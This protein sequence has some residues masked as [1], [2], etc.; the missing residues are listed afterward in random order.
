MGSTASLGAL[1]II[2]GADTD[3]LDKGLKGAQAS[4]SK[5]SDSIGTAMAV[6]GAAVAGASAAIGVA[7]KKTIDEA[8][9]MGKMSQSIGVPVEELSRLKYAADLSDVSLEALGKN[10]GKLSKNMV[11]V[12]AGGAGPAADAFKALGISV[13]NTDGRLKTSSEVIGEVAG[14]FET[15]KDG[16]GKTALAMAIFGKS[17]AEMIPLLNSG[18]DGLKE[19]ADEADRLGVVIDSK[20]AKSAEAF[21]DNMTRLNKVMGGIVLKITAEMAPAMEELST[22]LV[23]VSK[24]AD[25]LKGTGEGLSSVIRFITNDVIISATEFKRWLAEVTAV[26][27]VMKSPD[28]MHFGETIKTAWRTL[29][30]EGAKTERIMWELKKTLFAIKLPAMEYDWSSQLGGIPTPK[31]DWSG[32]LAGIQAMN[33]EV[34]KYAQEWAK[35]DPPIIRAGESA[36]GAFDKFIAGQM[37]AIAGQQAEFDATGMA[38]GA[39]ERLKTVLQGLTVAQANGII[40]ND[41]QR[42]KLTETANA[43]DLM[44]LK[45]GNLALIGQ[46]NPFVALGVQL[47]ATNL[48]LQEGGLKVQDYAILSEQA[49]LLTQ[50]LWTET[51]TSLGGSFESIGSSMSQL[52][53]DWAK[54]AKVGQSIGAAIAFVNSYVAASEA[55]AKTPFPANF[56]IAAGVLAKGMAMV[57]SIKSVSSSTGM[58]TGG[59]MTVRGSGGPDSVP[60]SFMASP[61]EQIDVWRPDQ[62]GGADPR[63]GGSGGGN[64]YNLPIPAVTTREAIGVLIGHLNEAIGDGH[65]INVVPV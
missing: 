13:T 33:K 47:D 2:L 9:K 5:F 45:L 31:M 21:N 11:D 59:A 28:W 34:E 36:K 29:G 18:K 37:K 12:A 19:M 30:E 46:T 54:F 35:A 57:A 6:A 61:G 62:G 63:R 17:G 7:I 16:A 3:A 43:A 38:I 26:W 23:T 1:R 8:D 14:K 24:D 60:I 4:L 32:Q 27:N 52:S 40:L 42:I 10:V 44:A 49:G 41:Q 25:L 39:K 22:K 55:F 15:Y 53:G 64:V 20:T 51:A 48:K 50:K 65:R 58:M 56:A